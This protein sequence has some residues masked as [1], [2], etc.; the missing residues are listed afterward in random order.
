MDTQAHKCKFF[1]YHATY[2][3]DDQ[4]SQRKADTGVDPRH[5]QGGLH[6]WL[7]LL[8]SSCWKMFDQIFL[9]RQKKLV[10][11]KDYHFTIMLT[12]NY[13]LERFRRKVGRT[14]N[15]I[16]FILTSRPGW[17]HIFSSEFSF[18]TQSYIS[19]R[20][21]HTLVK[22][23]HFNIPHSVTGSHSNDTQSKH[24]VKYHISMIFRTAVF[25]YLKNDKDRVSEWRWK[26]GS[27]IYYF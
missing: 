11:E 15:K 24:L 12:W 26:T 5:Y 4:D 21:G 18:C 3:T 9:R 20:P 8:W 17:F 2:T 22:K 13:R 6:L 14:N 19:F 10:A 16:D 1:T 7:T 27:C 23:N 25:Q